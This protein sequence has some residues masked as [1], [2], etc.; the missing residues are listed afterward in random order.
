MPL[1]ALT[2]VLNDLRGGKTSS[3]YP[4]Q[5]LQSLPNSTDSPGASE[6]RRKSSGLPNQ[7]SSSSTADEVSIFINCIYSPN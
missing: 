5:Q 4:Q 1:A 6:Y 2:P 3:S 7:L